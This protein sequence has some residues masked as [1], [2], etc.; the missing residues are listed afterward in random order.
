MYC[1]ILF[2]HIIYIFFVKL[3]VIIPHVF[4][5]SIHGIGNAIAI[6]IVTFNIIVIRYCF[7]FICFFGDS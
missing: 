1:L 5:L 3:N 4:D 2:A 7:N 6:F